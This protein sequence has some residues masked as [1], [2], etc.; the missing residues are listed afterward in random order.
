MVPHVARL[1][2]SDLIIRFHLYW[3]YQPS[4]SEVCLVHAAQLQSPT[5]ITACAG[6]RLIWSTPSAGNGDLIS[7]SFG[8]IF[9]FEFG[10]AAH[11][12]GGVH[13]CAPDMFSYITSMRRLFLPKSCV[14]ARLPSVPLNTPPS[15]KNEQLLDMH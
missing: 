7:P 15:M 11:V 1:S 10:S 6:S 13:S 14:Q 5:G 2:A 3:Q 8:L 12:A 4:G 9:E